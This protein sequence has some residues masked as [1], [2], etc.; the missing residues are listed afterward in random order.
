MEVVFKPPKPMGAKRKNVDSNRFCD[1]HK[2]V[3]HDTDNCYSLKMEI[4][5]ALRL[6]KLGNLV[7]NVRAGARR[8]D[9]TPK[10]IKDINTHFVHGT[11]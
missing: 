3:G 8:G 1:F 5:T 7:K 9:D 2:D 11:G 6:G 10:P 4:E